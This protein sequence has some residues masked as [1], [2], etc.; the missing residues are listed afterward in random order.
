MRLGMGLGLGNL[1]SGQPLTGFPNDFSFNF[2]GS[3]DYLEIDSSSEFNF[4]SGN[5]SFSLWMYKTVSTGSGAYDGL[6]FRSND[7]RIKFQQS[8]Q[9][10]F[11]DNG[12]RD[13]QIIDNGSSLLNAWHHIAIV[14]DGTTLTGY[15]NGQSKGTITLGGSETFDGGTNNLVIGQNGSGNEFGG[16]IDEVA[17][18]D[19]ALDATAIGKISSKVVDLTKYSA[20]NLKL[21]LRAGDKVLP[22]SDASIARSD[23]YTDFDGTDDYVSV[24]DNDDLSFGDGSS[25][26]PFSISA[27]INPVDATNFTIVSKGVYNT[28]AE[29]LF[30]LD[31]ND[32]LFFS[33]YDE[34]VDNTYEGAYFNTALTSYQGSWF[35]VCATYNG[36]GGTSANAGIKLY[37]DGVEKST[38]L[39]GGG[40]YVAM[41]NLRGS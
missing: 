11:F 38:T 20:S 30:Q 32:K 5:F 31:G 37:I 36:V 15:V 17:I 34:S 21:W 19:S 18:W 12:T 29:Y 13:E 22:E 24:A 33:L 28:D 14:R 25:D 3:N 39:I 27:W 16:L 40:T 10:I 6:F 2:D 26:S 9:I 35:H 8:D 23:F 4:G 7:W 1:L 41:E